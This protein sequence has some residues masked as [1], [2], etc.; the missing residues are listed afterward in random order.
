M[1]RPSLRSG[2]LL[3]VAGLT[4]VLGGAPLLAA[5]ADHLDAPALGGLSQ[6]GAFDPH[7]EHGDR[8]INDLYVF[9]GSNA[10]RTV[11]AMTTNPAIDLFGGSFGT[12]V[13]YILNVD[14]TGD[15]IQDLAYVVRFG[16]LTNGAQQYAVTRYDGANSRSL[17]HGVLVGWGSTAGNGIGKGI[18]GLKVFAGVRSDPFFFDLTGFVGTV[19]GL[20][21]DRLGD[22]PTDFFRYRNTNAIVIEVPD[23]ALGATHIGV[24]GKTTWWNGSAWM[25]G[26]QMGRPAINTVFNNAIVDPVNSGATKNAFNAVPPSQ[27]RTGDNGQFKANMLAT[28]ENIDAALGLTGAPFNCTDNSP[29]TANVLANILLPD[30]ITYDTSTHAVGPLNGRALSDDVIDTELG[31]TTNGCVT[32]DGVGPHSDYLGQFPYLGQP[33]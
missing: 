16:P 4:L 2:G 17:T 20:G 18:G 1:N 11:L 26:D 29:A 8:D 10:S 5:A 23:D 14:R 15:A 28:L 31:I 13:R 19:F 30:V 27:Q 7:S 24:W 21:S 32:S 6:N 9:D 25:P 22:N 33:H 12:N 3:A